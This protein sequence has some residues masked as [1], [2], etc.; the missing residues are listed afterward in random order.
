MTLVSLRPTAGRLALRVSIAIGSCLLLAAITSWA[1]RERQGADLEAAIEAELARLAATGAPMFPADLERPPVDEARNGASRVLDAVAA[2]PG[3]M[4]L[5]TSA[6]D[7]LAATPPGAEL[8]ELEMLRTVLDS[9]AGALATVSEA[10]RMPTVQFPLDLEAGRPSALPHLEACAT[11]SPLLRARARVRLT[12]GD[13]DGACADLETV[14]RL[15]RALE[16]EPLESSQAFLHRLL[17]RVDRLLPQAVAGAGPAARAS[18]DAQLAAFDPASQERRAL[19]AEGV[20]GL[21]TYVEAVD[22]QR[23]AAGA[24]GRDP[25]Y[26]EL[27]ADR[28]AFLETWSAVLALFD[29]P[30]AARAAELERLISALRPPPGERRLATSAV[31]ALVL[32]SGVATNREAGHAAGQIRQREPVAF[33]RLAQQSDSRRVAF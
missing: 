7:R 3:L 6:L 9:W 17:R 13:P 1:W 18:L 31:V 14:L 2:M 27:A 16:S 19:E 20:L 30:P 24:Q 32:T 12:D 29:R 5:E 33:Q 11:L 26:V 15:A 23:A 4:D 28:L 21:R 10:A 8:P 22:K 25:L